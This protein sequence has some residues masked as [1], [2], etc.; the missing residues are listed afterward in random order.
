MKEELK[1]WIKIDFA[2]E[3]ANWFKENYTIKKSLKWT[4][5]I[6]NK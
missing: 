6:Q 2:K 5:E 1:Q 3:I 4:I